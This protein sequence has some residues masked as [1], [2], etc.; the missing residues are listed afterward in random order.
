MSQAE[1]KRFISDVSSN[2]T[3][4]EAVVSASEGIES[5]V[6]I[7]QGHGYDINIDEAR[8]Y[9]MANQEGELN[10]DQLDAVA[11]GKSHPAVI[12]HESVATS[13]VTFTHSVTATSVH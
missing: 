10:D 3:L 5:L 12:T 7:A 11:G 6:A 9:I 4:R 1:I 2:E 13:V 8:D